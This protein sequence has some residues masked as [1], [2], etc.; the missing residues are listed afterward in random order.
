MPASAVLLIALAGISFAGPLVRLSHADALAIAVW[1]LGFSL[2]V[3]AIALAIT[4]SW[5]Q[6][7][8]L[9]ARA[10]LIALGAGAMLAI[11][12]WAWNAS[13][14]MTTVA[15]SVLLVNAQPAIVALLSM[16]WLH[17]PPTRRQWIGIAIAM[18]GAVVVALPEFGAST[19]PHSSRALL[20]DA[21]AF[22]GAIAG[23]TY[24]VAGRHLRETLDLWP[25]VGIVYGA[26]FVV[27][28]IF[29]G[30][31][32]AAVA[33]QPPRELAIFAALALG[34][35][36]LGHTGFNWAL[37]YMPAYVV[38]LTLLGEPVG[39]TL[40]AATL[41]GIRELPTVATFAGG[42]LILAGVYVAARA[43]RAARAAGAGGAA[44]DSPIGSEVVETFRNQNAD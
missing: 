26:C 3:I 44:V 24:F 19:G 8:R 6:W 40:L 18:L 14:S 30:L 33:P 29:A 13:V 20:G 23:A 22:L 27:L 11:H 16:V 39:A 4:G 43:A 17:E 42:A 37:K 36:L 7:R 15:A 9:D 12:F 21:L 38:N 41:P 34:P 31:T 32:H 1:R 2:I 5:R 25:Y 10:S 35:M 28:L